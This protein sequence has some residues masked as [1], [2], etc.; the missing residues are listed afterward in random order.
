MKRSPLVDEFQKQLSATPWLK[1]GLLAAGALGF[2]FA[3][4]AL[5]DA[6]G[7]AEAEAISEEVKL[8]KVRALQGQDIWMSRQEEAKALH[9]SL[10][11]EIPSAG[12]PG[13][14]Q[15][16]LQTWLRGISTSLSG[17]SDIRISVDEAV[18][19]EEPAGLIRVH[20]S[21]SGRMSARQGMSVLRQME[22]AT[23]L[24]VP[25]T[26]DIRSGTNNTVNMTLIAYYRAEPEQDE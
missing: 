14:A 8:R 7:Q 23:N 20:A 12:T 26:V 6:R 16:A 24:V 15:A 18:L 22:A 4:Q 9:D 1:W 11:A 3:W 21:F 17:A 5:A 10:R 25:E 19:M 13:L 2:L